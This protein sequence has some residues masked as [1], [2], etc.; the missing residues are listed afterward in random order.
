[1][2]EPVEFDFWTEFM[3]GAC[4]IVATLLFAG[5]LWVTSPVLPLVAIAVTIAWA[6]GRLAHLLIVRFGNYS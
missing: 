4:I 2:N 3:V 5:V 1:M 6:V